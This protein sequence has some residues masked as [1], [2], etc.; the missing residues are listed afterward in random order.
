LAAE[1]H[2]ALRSAR[3]RLFTGIGTR[4]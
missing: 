1:H 2:K 3:V 4:K